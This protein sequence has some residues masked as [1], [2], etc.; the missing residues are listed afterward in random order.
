MQRTGWLMAASMGLGTLAL[1]TLELYVRREYVFNLYLLNKAVASAAILL[2]AASFTISALV[3]FGWMHKPALAHRRPLGVVGFVLALG[4]IAL[5][6]TVPDPDRVS[7]F[8]FPFPGYFIEHAP[9]MLF[10]AIGFVIFANAFRLSLQQKRYFGTPQQARRSRVTLRYGYVGVLCI[11]A[12]ATLLKAE[13]W[14]TWIQ[15][16]DPPLPPLSLIVAVLLLLLIA[17]KTLHLTRA[18]R[19]F[20]D[21]TDA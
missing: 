13:G 6:L 15:K 4:H 18:G 11:A 20:R 12:H 17:L 7:A 16:P 9:A 19:L 5:T 2:I 8:K 21:R 14:S 1:G 10:A 3:H